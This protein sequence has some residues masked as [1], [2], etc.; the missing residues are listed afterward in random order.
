MSG[1][2]LFCI[3]QFWLKTV[4]W[5]QCSRQ[6]MEMQFIDLT[7]KDILLVAGDFM[8]FETLPHGQVIEVYCVVELAT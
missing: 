6:M 2:I 3:Q 4:V 1:N 7:D 5:F 8:N